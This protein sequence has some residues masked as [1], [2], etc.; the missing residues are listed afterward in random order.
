MKRLSRLWALLAERGQADYAEFRRRERNSLVIERLIRDWG[1]WDSDVDL[2]T[3][4]ASPFKTK[5]L[6][7]SLLIPWLMTKF[8]NFH[9]AHD[10]VKALR[11]S[12]CLTAVFLE[13]ELGAASFGQPFSITVLGQLMRVAPDF[14]LPMGGLFSAVP[15]LQGDWQAMSDNDR[16]VGGLPALTNEPKVGDVPCP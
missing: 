12:Q 8:R 11:A 1:L 14:R 6:Q 9:V 2:G 10:S 7:S 4:P 13:A 15:C 16:C 3:G 5:V